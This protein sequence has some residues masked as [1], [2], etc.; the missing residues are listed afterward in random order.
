VS[1]PSVDIGK[2]VGNVQKNSS[3]DEFIITV[4]TVGAPFS[5]TL[6]GSELD[7]LGSIISHWTGV[8]GFGYE[9]YN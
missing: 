6:S 9:K 4:Q 8:D 5:L 3:P 1:Q 2:V 7:S